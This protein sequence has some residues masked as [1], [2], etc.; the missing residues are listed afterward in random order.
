MEESALRST[1]QEASSGESLAVGSPVYSWYVMGVLMLANLSGFVDR[2]VMALLTDPIKADL[3]LTDTQVSWLGG[4]AF[5]LFYSVLGFPIGRLADRASRRAIIGW[6]IAIWSAMCALCGVARGYGQ[7]FWARVGVGVGEASLVPPAFSLIADY[8]PPRRLSAAMSVFGVGSFLGSGIA[9]LFGGIVIQYVEQVGTVALPVVGLLRPW[10]LVFV[11]VGLPGLVVALLMLTV[12]EP[13]RAHG[14]SSLP[15]GYSVRAT[16]NHI[17]KH[18]VA[19][20]SQGLGFGLFLLVNL[21]TAFWFPAFFMRTQGW[22]YAQVGLYMGLAT[23]IFG[24]LGIL[25]GGRIADWLKSRGRTDANLRVGIWG[26]VFALIAAFPLYLAPSFAVLMAGLIATNLAAA[27]PWGAAPAALQEMTPAPMR[28]QTSALYLVLITLVSAFG[29]TAVALCTDHVFHDDAM[30]G[31]ALLLV[32]VV[33][34]VFSAVVLALGLGAFRR[35]VS[36]AAAA[37]V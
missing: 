20:S 26:S 28:G 19:F 10:Q 9:Y 32:T 13:A 12:R 23:I 5:A 29:P 35:A 27:F 17:G 36:A 22:N 18:L 31:R 11:V 33:G 16:F 1:A 8:F 7:L 4:L 2:Q 30:V 15:A 3:R 21:G 14:G 37:A 24:T 25:A 34:R 6:G